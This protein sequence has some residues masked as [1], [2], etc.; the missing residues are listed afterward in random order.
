MIR[1]PDRTLVS[2]VSAFAVAGLLFAFTLV[3]AVTVDETPADEPYAMS[4]TRPVPQD[5]SPVEAR[6]PSQGRL[7]SEA[8]RL[9]VDNDPFQADRTPPPPY[10]MPGENEESVVVERPAPPPPPPF[11]LLGT[12][13]MPEKSVA[14]LQVEDAT[15]QIVTVGEAVMGYTLKTVEMTSATLTS[16]SGEELRLAVSP[17]SASPARAS[18]RNSG[19]GQRGNARGNSRAQDLRE[20]AIKNAID[21]LRQQNAAPEVIERLMQQ[22][23]G[24]GDSPEAVIEIGPPRI[25]LRGNVRRDTSSVPEPR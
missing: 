23:N 24:R 1:T 21:R 15:P 10:R 9:A 2:A 8:L 5:D 3:R 6:V 25:I 16:R 22:L 20:T 11:Q 14:L 12:V 4:G 13:S 7:S 18:G 17:P 19:R